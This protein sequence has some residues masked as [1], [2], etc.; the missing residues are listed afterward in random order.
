MR[1]AVAGFGP[2]S[3]LAGALQRCCGAVGCTRSAGCFLVMGR[4]ALVARSLARSSSSWELRH[5]SHHGPDDVLS[6]IALIG[7]SSRRP[8]KHQHAGRGTTFRKRIGGRARPVRV[9]ADAFHR[10]DD[11]AA[12][13][14]LHFLDL[15]EA[16]GGKLVYDRGVPPK[17]SRRRPN[18]ISITRTKPGD[19]AESATSM[20]MD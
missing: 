20:T 1:A 7:S 12:E 14:E 13:R 4:A 2:G 10:R 16:K 17:S 5:E 6:A 9:D 3:S 15:V 18:K 8:R 19:C 11:H